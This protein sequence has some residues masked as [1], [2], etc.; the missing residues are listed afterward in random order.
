MKY[1]AIYNVLEQSHTRI[2]Y[3]NSG[4]RAARPDYSDHCRPLWIVAESQQHNLRLWIT[5]ECGVLSVTTAR[6]DQDTSSRAYHESQIC[7]KFR[8]Q[9]RLAAYLR[10]LLLPQEG[11]TSECAS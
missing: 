6:L 9:E 8:T 11:G 5:H 3:E 1:K 4:W 2:S 7:K 10:E